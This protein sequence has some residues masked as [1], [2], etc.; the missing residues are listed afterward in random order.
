MSCL[1]I[2][3]GWLVAFTVACL[4]HSSPRACAPGDC[5][6]EFS[7]E[8][9]VDRPAGIESLEQT[10]RAIPSWEGT[11]ANTGEDCPVP[12]NQEVEYKWELEG[13]GQL[14]PAGQEAEVFLSA[15]GQYRVLLTAKDERWNYAS[16]A[17]TLDVLDSSMPEQQLAH[18]DSEVQYRGEVGACQACLVASTRL[19]TTVAL[20]RVRLATTHD[21]VQG[22]DLADWSDLTVQLEPADLGC[23]PLPAG[24]GPGD[25][26]HSLFFIG[27]TKQRG[28]MSA[29]TPGLLPCERPEEDDED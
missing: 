17:V 22:A 12:P 28:A 14:V 15:P 5:E 6:V 27:G 21:S 23:A 3:P 20:E 7:V 10:L 25:Q 16:A 24:F 8:V 19:P 26:V 9:Q 4:P 18:I 1:R 11:T 2:H 13:E 29:L